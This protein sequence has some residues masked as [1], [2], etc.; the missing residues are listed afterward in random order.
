[1]TLV[2]LLV[3]LALPV[4]PPAL[5]GSVTKTTVPCQSPK[6]KSDYRIDQ[7]L[8]T[9][10][11]IATSQMNAS[12]HK[13]SDFF[14]YA[15]RKQDWRVAHR[16]QAT[17]MAYARETCLAETNPY[18]SGTIEPILYGECALQLF[19]QRLAEIRRA[20]TD[21]RNGGESQRSS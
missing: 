19:H 15:T 13:E 8:V 16:T 1:V 5:A 17:F 7:C 4:A 18:S 2:A 3:A 14:R 10:M 11:K 12:L 6:L 9:Q 21:F 20:I